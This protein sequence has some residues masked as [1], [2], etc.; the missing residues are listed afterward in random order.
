MT[1]CSTIVAVFRS[2]YVLKRSICNFG[3]TSLDWPEPASCCLHNHIEDLFGFLPTPP[4]VGLGI[5]IGTYAGR[6]SLSVA[7]DR[8]LMGDSANELLGLMMAE[9]ARYCEASCEARSYRY[10]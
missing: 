7:C 4:G 6:A 5:A 3:S 9:H 8:T 10:E 2:I 1:G